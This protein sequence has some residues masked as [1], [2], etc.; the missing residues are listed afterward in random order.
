MKEMGKEQVG[1]SLTSRVT[2]S[3]FFTELQLAHFSVQ[4]YLI[5]TQ[6]E[7][8]PAAKFKLESRLANTFI[9]NTC[10][11]YLSQFDKEYPPMHS[12]LAHLPLTFYAAKYWVQHACS[13]GEDM[14]SALH[15]LVLNFF[16]TKKIFRSWVRIFDIDRQH[17]WREETE[18]N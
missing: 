13:N 2:F 10:L 14:P 18:L 3:E 1:K 7:S 9:A 8:G 4:D 16:Q 6:I 12:T 11:I 17:G 15:K 5:S